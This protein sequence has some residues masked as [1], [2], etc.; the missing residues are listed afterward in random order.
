MG[1]GG[2]KIP[3][4]EGCRN[5][6]V[7]MYLVVE[8]LIWYDLWVSL[9]RVCSVPM[10]CFEPIITEEEYVRKKAFENCLS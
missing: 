4:C 7:L 5:I 3:P 2:K 9:A 6:V 1:G 8:Y 10:Y